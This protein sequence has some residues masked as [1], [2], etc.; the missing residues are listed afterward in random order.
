V[1][2][3]APLSKL[4]TAAA[5]TAALY[6]G[7]PPAA[8]GVRLPSVPAPPY[9]PPVPPLIAP[10]EA[11]RTG[12]AGDYEA[13]SVQLP[14]P[15]SRET[16][17]YTTTRRW[18]ACDVYVELPT[19]LTAASFVLSVFVYAVS[20]WG[21]KTLVASGRINGITTDGNGQSWW[22]PAKWIVAARSV[23][24]KYEVTAFVTQQSG[25]PNL[26]GTPK[27]TVVASD[28]MTE[29]P[30]TVGAIM[31][32]A[33]Q[34]AGIRLSA[35]GLNAPPRLEVLGVQGV[36]DV[37]AAR[38]LQLYDTSATSFGAITTAGFPPIAQWP[39]GAAIG[40]G[41]SD[42]TFRYRSQSPALASVSPLGPALVISTTPGTF[43]P[44]ADG[45]VTMMVR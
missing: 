40:G 38:Y 21:Q 8:P 15:R 9:D 39:M 27:L 16:T 32:R 23:A 29:P 17:F 34:G 7:V 2:L 18:R 24:E 13:Y 42:Y 28:E 35:V 37:A 43:T 45:W 19:Q 26:A 10:Q 36:N 25:A 4:T 31:L 6:P 33:T 44:A 12:V 30:P 22:E 41:I 5:R 20:Q 1:N 14:W 11:P 3:K